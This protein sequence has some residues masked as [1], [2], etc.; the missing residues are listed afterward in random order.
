MLDCYGHPL[1]PQGLWAADDYV[2]FSAAVRIQ[3]FSDLDRILK[4]TVPACP[5]SLG[6]EN[7]KQFPA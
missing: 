4:R 6:S 7:V 5:P 2:C 1:V 3:Y